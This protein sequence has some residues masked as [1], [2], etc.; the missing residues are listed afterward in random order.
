MHI[1]YNEKRTIF[2]SLIQS[3]SFYVCM[4]YTETV[5]LFLKLFSGVP[6]AENCT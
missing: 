4:C 6:Q 3:V 2:Q 5:I 1:K